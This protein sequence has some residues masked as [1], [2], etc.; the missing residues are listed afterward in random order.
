M[1]ASIQRACHN[2]LLKALPE[3]DFA[4][5][6]PHLMTVPLRL[7]EVLVKPDTP[8]ERVCFVEDGILS[9][10]VTAADGKQIELALVG[11][12]G[13]VGVPVLFGTDRSPHE[14]RVQATGY[15]WSVSSDALRKVLGS[16]PGLHALLLRYVQSLNVQVAGT[17]LAN[18]RYK[19]EQRLARWLLMCHDRTEGD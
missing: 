5:L 6:Q 12:E 4:L 8:I 3:A 14:D 2:R 17:A 9:H 11:R 15:A 10:I 13:M 16:S 19:L 7:A 18:T 1:P